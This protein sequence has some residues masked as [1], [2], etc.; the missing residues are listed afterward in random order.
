[1]WRR[2]WRSVVVLTLIVSFMLLAAHVYLLNETPSQ[3]RDCPFCQWLQNL[4]QG[5]Q[6]AIVVVG[7]P[8]F[9]R[10]S[11]EPV[12]VLSEKPHHLLFLARS[13]PAA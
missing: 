7:A 6:P 4:V 13:P 3:Q 12:L 2:R 10:A 8:L 5:A 9:G 11:P 1:M